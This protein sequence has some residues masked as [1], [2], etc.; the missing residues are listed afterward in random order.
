MH[1]PHWHWHAG[2]AG[3]GE[4]LHHACAGAPRSALVALLPPGEHKELLRPLAV[5]LAGSLG[6]DEGKERL[7]SLQRCAG[8]MA[9]LSAIARVA[10][11]I[12]AAH[13]AA[14]ADF[15]LEA[16]GSPPGLH[17]CSVAS[18]VRAAR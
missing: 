5:D 14:V 4:A 9:A 10:P 16:R 1:C 8:T 13:A 15:V 6:L 12:F 18:F 7:G 11:D 3:K 2:L 17:A